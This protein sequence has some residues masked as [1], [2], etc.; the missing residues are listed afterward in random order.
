MESAPFAYPLYRIAQRHANVVIAKKGLAAI[1][2]DR[3]IVTF[4]VKK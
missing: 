2:D 3:D 1:G 4:T